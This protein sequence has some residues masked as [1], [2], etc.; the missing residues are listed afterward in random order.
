MKFAFM[1]KTTVNSALVTLWHTPA[2]KGV[3][4]RKKAEGSKWA[5]KPRLL[6]AS[7][8]C[9]LL[10]LPVAT[11]KRLYHML[12]QIEQRKGIYG[13]KREC[14]GT[15]REH[16]R[17]R[18]Y[19]IG[20]SSSMHV[21]SN[22]LSRERNRLQKLVVGYPKKLQNFCCG[23]WKHNHEAQISFLTLWY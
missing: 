11:W 2:L 23:V 5:S 17:T 9:A 7:S 4:A 1:N 15:S 12:Y 20:E 13:V 16:E 18:K 8:P 10:R 3:Q 6:M 22:I 19:S 14:S 21:Y